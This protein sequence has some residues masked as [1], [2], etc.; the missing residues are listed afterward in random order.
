MHSGNAGSACLKFKK[1]EKAYLS[2]MV[3]ERHTLSLKLTLALVFSRG[4]VVYEYGTGQQRLSKGMSS[5]TT[6]PIPGFAALR[7]TKDTL[8]VA[9]VTCLN[10]LSLLSFTL[11][12]VN[13]WGGE[14]RTVL[15]PRRTCVVM[16]M[17]IYLHELIQPP[18]E[19]DIF[20]K[21]FIN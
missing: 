12:H 3:L 4:F 2:Y 19:R 20:F 7:H 1:N 10:I 14:W 15:P 6:K 13:S 9:I 5:Q 8:R 16:Y 21:P 11:E 18:T 17:Y